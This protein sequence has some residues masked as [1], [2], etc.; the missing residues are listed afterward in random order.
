MTPKSERKP[1]RSETERPWHV[2]IVRCA[3]GTLYTG[4]TNDIETRIAAH[5]AGRG[6]RYTRPRRPVSLLYIEPAGARGAALRRE[7]EIKRLPREQ[8]QRLALSVSTCG[9]S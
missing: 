1:G 7:Y 5:N 2:Y 4:V 9:G 3:D 6:A 8:K